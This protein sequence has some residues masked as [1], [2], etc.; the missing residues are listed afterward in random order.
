MKS[1]LHL[2]IV[3]GLCLTSATHLDAY[4]YDHEIY[5]EIIQS[6]EETGV[7]LGDR[8]GEFKGDHV[9][10]LSDGSAWKIHPKNHKTYRQWDKGDV[11]TI[12]VRT[13]RYWFKREH[14]FV[15]YNYSRNE[16]V[17]VMLVCHKQYPKPLKVLVTD[18]FCVGYETYPEV[19]WITIYRNDGTTELV[20]VTEWKTRPVYRKALGLSDGTIWE[21]K[22]GIDDFTIGTHVYVGAQYIDNDDY[23]FILIRG[24]QREARWTWASC[25]NP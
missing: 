4:L 15:L 14:K 23:D 1:F 2:M 17:N 24:D 7:F 19:K 13:D 20:S 25:L 3:F 9:A 12:M 16:T 22:D 21:I 11:V 18:S 8:H 6:I 5:P 10:I